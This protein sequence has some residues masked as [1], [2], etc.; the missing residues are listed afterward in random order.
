[1]SERQNQ[2]LVKRI[3]LKVERFNTTLGKAL[4]KPPLVKSDTAIE[5]TEYLEDFTLLIG[6]LSPHASTRRDVSEVLRTASSI[7]RLLLCEEVPPRVVIDWASLHADLDL[8]AR[9]YGLKWSEVV[10]TKELVARFEN[11]VRSFSNGLNVEL[12]SIQIIRTAGTR[13]LPELMHQFRQAAQALNSGY[14]DSARAQ[15][16]IA[17]LS[18]CTR[19]ISLY[20]KELTLGLQLQADWRRLSA[21]VEELVRI[22]NLD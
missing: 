20:L 21:Q 11:E 22:Y 3:S 1:L 17:D 18:S 16:Q 15:H 5:F 2:E 14:S 9:V 8:L 4:T 6:Q 12:P 7:E 19:M 10:V 13:D